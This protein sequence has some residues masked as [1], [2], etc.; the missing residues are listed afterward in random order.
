MHNTLAFTQLLYEYSPDEVKM[1]KATEISWDR[2]Y[3]VTGHIPDPAEA[4]STRATL[5]EYVGMPTLLETM[6]QQIE[7]K[8]DP[9]AE[10]ISEDSSTKLEQVAIREIA[11]RFLDS[12]RAE[13]LRPDSRHSYGQVLNQFAREYPFLPDRP[14]VIEGFLTGKKAAITRRWIYNILS[15]L[16]KFAYSRFSVPNVMEG[17]PKPIVR[18]KE[19]DS[20]TINQARDFLEAIKNEREMGLVCL[21]LGQGLRLSESVR[22]DIG[23]DRIR[24]NG[25][26]REEFMPPLPEV[27]KALLQL[28]GNRP[29]TDPVFTSYRGRRLGRDMAGIVIKEIFKRAGITGI[30]Q[31]PHTLRHTFATLA[32]AAGCDTY[33]VECL[34]RHR[35]SGWNVTYHYI[36]LT[37]EDLKEKLE[38]YSPLRTVLAEDSKNLLEDE[39]NRANGKADVGKLVY[40]F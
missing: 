31:S 21:Y 14:E 34:L 20:L 6:L 26:E 7:Q 11:D 30:K 39:S 36:H 10:Q 4:S 5:L 2:I 23:E 33:S 16:Y 19:P 40:S 12:K 17:I 28:A 38:K 24:I 22:L 27:R 35:S 9:Q 18:S 8:L 15:G 29:V 32:T 1:N 3:E 37:I 25:K 13:G